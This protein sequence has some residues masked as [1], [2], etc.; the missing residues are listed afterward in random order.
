MDKTEI[1]EIL[2]GSDDKKAYA[3]T[4]EMCRESEL[5]DRYY[6]LLDEFISLAGSGRSYERVR[7]FRL[8]CAQARWDSLKKLDVAFDRLLALL[9]DEKPTAVRQ[10]LAALGDAAIYK[11]ALRNMIADAAAGID[12]SKFKSSMAPLIKKDAEALIDRIGKMT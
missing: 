11:P 5:S 1:F 9:G 3:L 12:L 6:S 2:Q 10:Y 7:G 4:V 8:V